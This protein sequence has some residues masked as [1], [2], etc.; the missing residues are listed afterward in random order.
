MMDTKIIRG[1]L[2]VHKSFLPVE[3]KTANSYGL[4]FLLFSI[5]RSLLGQRTMHSSNLFLNLA[6]GIYHV[7]QQKQ[8]ISSKIV[9]K[10]ITKNMNC[11]TLLNFQLQMQPQIVSSEYTSPLIKNSVI[12]EIWNNYGHT[13]TEYVNLKGVNIKEDRS[14]KKQ[15]N[16]IQ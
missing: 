4:I 1:P 16:K 13:Y 12:Q 6:T 8:Y 5:W 10:L 14:I 9:L 2:H 3:R 15:K 7:T 11:K